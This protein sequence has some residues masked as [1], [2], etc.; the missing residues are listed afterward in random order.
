M[1][2]ETTRDKQGSCLIALPSKPFSS[3]GD[4][5]AFPNTLRSARLLSRSQM[6]HEH[7]H[8]ALSPQQDWQIGR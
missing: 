7:F 4:A 3:F 6:R 8:A 5:R 1:L 2:C